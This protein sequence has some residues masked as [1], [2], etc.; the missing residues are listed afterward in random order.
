MNGKLLP[1]AVG[2]DLGLA[3]HRVFTVTYGIFRED[4][5]SFSRQKSTRQFL[6]GGMVNFQRFQVGVPLILISVKQELRDMLRLGLKS[7]TGGR[8]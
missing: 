7:P 6:A 3:F 1:R 5:D 2:E 8:V 4:G